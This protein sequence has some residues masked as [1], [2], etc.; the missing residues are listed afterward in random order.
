MGC[1]KGKSESKEKPGRFRCKS[2][3]AVSDKKCH[4][5]KPEKIKKKKD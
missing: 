3:G 5:C 2:C 4:C 1:M